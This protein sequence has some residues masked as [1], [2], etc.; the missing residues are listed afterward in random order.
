MELFDIVDRNDN[1]VGTTDKKTAH[2][3]GQLHRVAAVF[4][5]DQNGELYVQQHPI[6]GKWDHSVG[7][8]VS[9]GETYALAAAREAEEELGITQPLEELATS[10]YADEH[11]HMQHMFGIYT[12]VANPDWE[13]IPNPND[14]VEVIFPMSIIAIRETMS[15]D[16]E[17]FTAGFSTTMAEYARLNGL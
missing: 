12:C 15:S 1:V 2:S 14:K 8:H 9:Q 13:F 5:F 3:T 10:I 11:P 17:K 16:P 6:D 4:V 7:G